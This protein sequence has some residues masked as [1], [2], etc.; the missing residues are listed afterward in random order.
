MMADV[1]IRRENTT[2]LIKPRPIFLQKISLE[3]AKKKGY[4]SF[5]KM[6]KLKKDFQE[7]Q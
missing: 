7:A 6:S 1:L 2:E 5:M 4:H 3:R